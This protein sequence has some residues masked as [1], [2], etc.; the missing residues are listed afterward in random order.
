V[1]AFST[2]RE[3]V[4][5]TILLV[6]SVLPTETVYSAE[7]PS[8]T[9]I[10]GTAP[11][12]A[13]RITLTRAMSTIDAIYARAATHADDAILDAA[14]RL[15][16]SIETL[17]QSRGDIVDKRPNSL[18]A[19]QKAALDNIESA[20]AALRMA[21]EAPADQARERITDVR[22]L[23]S[24]LA[25]S[26]DQP[27]VVATSPSILVPSA[28]SGGTLTL[29][30]RLLSKADPRLFFGDVEATR[31]GLTDTE[32]RFAVPAEALR[33]SD[34]IPTVYHGRALLSVRNCHWWGS[35]KP[36]LQTYSVGVV[37]L[38]THLATVRIGFDRKKN[39]RIY[40]QAPAAASSPSGAPAPAPADMLYKRRFEYSTEDLTVM[41]CTR[42]SQSPHAPGYSIDTDSLSTNVADHSGQT[43]WSIQ[44]A[45]AS[46]FEIELCAQPQIDKMSKTP[47]A[48][49][50]EV[51]WKE[52]RMGDVVSQR[53]WR[54][55]EGLDWGAHV[56]ES[57]PDDTHT[58]EVDLEYFDGSHATFSQTSND[59]YVEMKWDAQQHQLLLTPNLRPRLPDLP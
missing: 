6:L 40:E 38:P 25:P 57:L 44:N 54:Q 52:F 31:T 10:Y 16:F 55:P 21:A 13:T 51:T 11:P 1:A 2:R 56:A 49:S 36:S 26:P 20:V 37:M 41:S 23:T 18:T 14:A 47:G 58:V 27:S 33:S 48:I 35:C 29:S 34:R 50:V 5:A 59:R 22:Q 32:A 8:T 28:V 39:Q 46:G 45:S 17:E 9:I 7:N 53:E 19:A 4:C 42:E 24:N 43:K 3:G 12:G 30:G 15:R